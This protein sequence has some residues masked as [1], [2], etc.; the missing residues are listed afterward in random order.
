LND[1]GFAEDQPIQLP[2]GAHTITATYAADAT[3]SYT[4][5]ASSNS[6]SVTITQATTATAVATSAN[7]IATGG[8]ITLTA[9][10]SSLSNSALGPTGTVQFLSGGSNL[11]SAATC[12][13]AGAT[14]DINGNFV[15]AS[16]TAKLTTTLSALP[17]VFFRPQ[18][19]ATPWII[20]AWL[21]ALLALLSFVI[22]TLQ[23]T[24]RRRFAYAGLILAFV[25]TA[26][27]AGC[28]GG[29]G[30]GGGGGTPR[31]LSAKYAGDTNYAGSTSTAVT[32]TLQ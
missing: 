12:T 20:V 3:S 9:T 17:P 5:Q 4:S 14:T 23:A 22:A 31:S 30:G 21:A 27:I 10:V 6:L 8:S 16:C 2:A 28:G 1:R 25:A 15:G 29:S 32:V 7:T 13:P 24:R 18:P 11:G 19:R 26:A